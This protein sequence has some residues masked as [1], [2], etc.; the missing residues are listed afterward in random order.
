M[1]S[2]SAMQ[3]SFSPYKISTITSNTNIVNKEGEKCK[4]DL[5]LLFNCIAVSDNDEVGRF[6]YI[7]FFHN[8]T[9]H[10][11][12][13]YPPKKRRSAANSCVCEGECCCKCGKK[14][15]FDN[16]V[17][18]IYKMT[19]GYYPN[20]KVF[21]NGNI[22]MTGSRSLED[23]LPVIDYI[24][25][26]INKLRDVLLIDEVFG[27]NFIVRMINTDFTV[28]NNDD[29]CYINRKKLHDLLIK[30]NDIISWFDPCSKYHGVKIEY[31]WYKDYPCNHGC[32]KAGFPEPVKGFNGDVKDIAILVFKSGKIIMT[33]AVSME[34]LDEVYEYICGV[35][36][37][38]CGEILSKNV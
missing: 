11:R 10:A 29:R 14:R 1:S 25:N 20:L 17:T 38:N 6:I 26:E 8:K 18:L 4:I 16:Q 21:Q 31:R 23:T 32:R 36:K 13:I 27:A 9:R 12:G 30:D 3:V 22:Q 24:I 34:Q 28:Y 19:D 7:Q 2:N 35:I 37:R 15:Q 33:G 5:K